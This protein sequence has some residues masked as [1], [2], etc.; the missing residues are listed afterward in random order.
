M[1]DNILIVDNS[2]WKS[3]LKPNKEFKCLME[4]FQKIGFSLKAY[5]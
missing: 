4:F 3:F 5:Q 2:K 1:L